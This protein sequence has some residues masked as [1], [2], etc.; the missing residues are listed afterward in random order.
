MQAMLAAY[1]ETTSFRLENTMRNCGTSVLSVPLEPSP[2]VVLHSSSLQVKV[3]AYSS[4]VRED[5]SI[6]VWNGNIKYHS[7]KCITLGF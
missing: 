4:A 3:W 5:I 7:H 2:H 6:V 1:M